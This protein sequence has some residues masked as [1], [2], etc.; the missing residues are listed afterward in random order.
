MCGKVGEAPCRRCVTR[1]RR[2]PAADP[3]PGL[4]ACRSLLVYAGASRRLVTGLKYRN[5][6]AAL[7]WLAG[8]LA[9]LLAPPSG[10]VVAWAPTTARRR[11]RRGF[12]QAELLARALA[13]RWGL[14]C[15]RLLVRTGGGGG[16]QT[17]ASRA[18]RH[19]GPA[20]AVARPVRTPV[21]VVDDVTTTG[22]TLRAAAEALR[23]AGAPWVGAVTVARTP[24][25]LSHPSQGDNKTLK[26]AGSSTEYGQ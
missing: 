5:H 14:P 7:T 24:R 12:D 16:A 15:R 1:L 10:A 6:R 22:A 26:F 13:R 17:G 21:V 3:P 4:D 8:R 2:A 9:P 18:E 11:H 19:A 23:R 25:H 20:F